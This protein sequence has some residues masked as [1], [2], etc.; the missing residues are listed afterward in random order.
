MSA[1]STARTPDGA[2]NIR[3]DPCDRSWEAARARGGAAARPA[4]GYSLH[5][6]EALLGDCDVAELPRHQ[7]IHHLFEARAHQAPVVRREPAE[8][9]A[10]AAAL[11]GCLA[12]RVLL[13]EL[14]EFLPCHVDELGGVFRRLLE[15]SHL[16]S[17]LVDDPAQQRLRLLARTRH[18]FSFGNYAAVVVPHQDVAQ[19]D[20]LRAA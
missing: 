2:H 18:L 7:H 13:A 14:R 6:V 20:A 11:A 9:S 1:T 8:V 12:L 10:R 3:V 4:S 15:C 16:F 17:H 5:E 19:P